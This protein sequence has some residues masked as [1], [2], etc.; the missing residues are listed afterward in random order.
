MIGKEKKEPHHPAW[1]WARQEEAEERKRKPIRA[2]MA[3]EGRRFVVAI[4][5]EDKV[6]SKWL[7]ERQRREENREMMKMMRKKILACQGVRRVTGDAE[8]LPL[9]IANTEFARQ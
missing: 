4:A 3:M 9:A 1:E 5:E 8:A 6:R 7:R 2:V